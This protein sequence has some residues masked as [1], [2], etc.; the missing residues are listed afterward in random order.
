MEIDSFKYWM[1]QLVNRSENT[2]KAYKLHFNQFLEFMKATPDALIKMQRKALE[3]DGDPRKNHVVETKVRAWLGELKQSKSPS[4]C[5]LA[6]SSVKSFFALNLHPLRLTRLDRPQGESVGS[7]IPEKEEVI[8]IADATKWKYRAAVMFLK[9]SGLRISDLVRVRWEDAVDLGEG[10][11]N[12]NIMTQKKQVQAC[13]FVGPETT[14][15]LNQFKNKSGRIFGANKDAVN[16]MVNLIIEKAGVEGVSAHGLRKYFKT[17]L[18]HARVPEEYILRMMGKKA[19]VYSENRRSQ[20]F[21]AYKN[22]YPDLS[23]YAQQ[24]QAEEIADLRTELKEMQK[25]K[26]DYEFLKP[27][28][29]MAKAGKAA[30][31]IPK[32]HAKDLPL[33]VLETIKKFITPERFEAIK[34]II[35]EQKRQSQSRS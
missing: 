21:E 30:F 28:I 16:R 1:D 29:E 10:F 13:A 24:A 6:L 3:S 4:T 2:V 25:I 15:L 32:K 27:L 11:W 17:S 8:R 22:A 18:Q 14:R 34:K 33:E 35:Q 23:I 19:S 7:R 5:R 9:D 12:F 20:L 31:F 26:E